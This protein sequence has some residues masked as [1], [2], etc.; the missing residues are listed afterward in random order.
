MSMSITT[1][2]TNSTITAQE[3]CAAV[4]AIAGDLFDQLGGDTLYTDGTGPV[5]YP[6]FQDSVEDALLVAL[7]NLKP[8]DFDAEDE[9]EDELLCKQSIAVNVDRRFD[10]RLVYEVV[11]ASDGSDYGTVCQVKDLVTLEEWFDDEWI[12]ETQAPERIYTDNVPLT[13]T[14]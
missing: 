2:T 10:G 7:L 12:S 13:L 9:D 1:F 6:P 4:H 3:A 5:S 14:Y 8:A 11:F